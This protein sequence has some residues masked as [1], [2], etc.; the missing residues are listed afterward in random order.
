MGNYRNLSTGEKW[1]IGDERRWGPGRG[2]WE[3]VPS[4]SFGEVIGN[5]WTAF[6]D[7]RRPICTK[8]GAQRRAVGRKRPVVLDNGRSHE[9]DGMSA[10]VPAS[11]NRRSRKAVAKKK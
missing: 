7:A 10:A 8:E 4:Y 2:P 1:R 3:K 6:K 5:M 11:A 9:I